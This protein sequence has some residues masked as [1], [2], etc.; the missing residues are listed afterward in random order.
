MT[1]KEAI[2]SEVTVDVNDTAIDKVLL[3]RGLTGQVTYSPASHKRSANLAVAD[4]LVIAARGAVINEGKRSFTM[5]RGR[6]INNAK[7]LYIENGEPEK[8]ESLSLVKGVDKSN[9]W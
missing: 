4:L 9:T 6:L 2:L 3:D 1:L 5:S 8:A 7:R